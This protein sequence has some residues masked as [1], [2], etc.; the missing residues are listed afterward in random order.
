MKECLEV[1]KLR[2]GVYRIQEDS[3]YMNVDAYLVCGQD[4]AVMIDGL[5]IMDG[6]LSC[7]RE[8]T[9]LPVSMVVTHGHPDHAGKGM[10]EFLETGSEVFMSYKDMET[11]KGF[12]PEMDLS[13]IRELNDGDLLDLG[14][15]KLRCIAMPGHTGGS[16]MLYSEEDRLLFSGDAI[17]S[18]GFW[19]QLP[20]SSPLVVFRQ[21]LKKLEQLFEE[22]PAIKIYPGHSWQITPYIDNEDYLDKAYVDELISLTDGL[23]AGTVK[24]EKKS[25]EMEGMEKIDVRSVAGKHVTD[26]CY[27]AEHIYSKVVKVKQINDHIWLLNEND[28]STGYLVTGSKKALMID[29]MIGYE[30]LKVLVSRLTD[31]PIEVVNTHGHPDHIYG[32]A[33]F[34]KAYIHPADMEL[35]M[36]YQSEEV[37]REELEKRS[38]KQAEFVPV[39]EGHVFDL[40][41]VELEVFA[42]PGHTPGGIVLLDRKDRILFVG[43]SILEQTWMQLPESLTMEQ[44]VKSLERIRDLRGEFDYLLTGHGRGLEDGAFS[45]VHLNAVK[46]VAQGLNEHDEPYTWFGGTCM[47]HPYGKAPRKIVYK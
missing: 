24:G 5:G 15:R 29:T 40:G 11:L 44:F 36:K 37:Y 20:N 35:A 43:D 16:F 26:Y 1:T 18:G 6:L 27:D 45:E 19:M 13:G 21:E 3:E 22:N 33:Y 30:D 32:N 39:E 28:E 34:E 7:V 8:L 2:E 14:G 17:G 47:A 12:V 41:G 31:L 38:L 46:E 10:I 25:I 42:L 9:N 23:I 4:K